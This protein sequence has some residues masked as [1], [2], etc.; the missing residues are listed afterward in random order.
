MYTINSYDNENYDQNDFL[1][2][3]SSGDEIFNKCYND[4][5]P[6]NNSQINNSSYNNDNINDLAIKNINTIKNEIIPNNEQHLDNSIMNEERSTKDKTD[7][8]KTKEFFSKD[9]II[10]KLLDD[11][12]KDK[13]NNSNIEKSNEYYFLKE[14]TKRRMHEV[15]FT[16]VIIE[17]PKKRKEGDNQN[18]LQ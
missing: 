17:K 1:N 12:I 3:E 15:D 14:K 7:N 10:V 18:L 13:F 6:Q 8:K 2:S 5:F 11:T 9:K 4:I 16:G